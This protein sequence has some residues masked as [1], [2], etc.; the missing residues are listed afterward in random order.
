VVY[1]KKPSDADSMVIPCCLAA[2]VLLSIIAYVAIL[3][4][5]KFKRIKTENA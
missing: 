1:F 3:T 5:I 4:K 2:G